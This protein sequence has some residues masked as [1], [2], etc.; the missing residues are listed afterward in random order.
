[1]KK[2]S[3]L[4]LGAF[5]TLSANAAIIPPGG[6]GG[7][8]WLAASNLAY[9]VAV[10][11]AGTG[12][13]SAV[14]AT[15]IAQS[16]IAA[17]NA[18]WQPI[19][20]DLTTIGGLGNQLA[21]RILFRDLTDHT[22]KYLGVGSGLEIAGTTLN[23]SAGD[24]IS[25]SL[26]NAGLVHVNM[27][28]ATRI[29]S[30]IDSAGNVNIASFGDSLGAKVSEQIKVL[31]SGTI[32]T[33]G[34]AFVGGIYATH[35]NGAVTNI[36]ANTNWFLAH[37]D[38]GPSGTIE[39]SNSVGSY[40]RANTNHVYYLQEPGA[41]TFKVQSSLAGGAWTDL[42]TIDA[43]G[44]YG[45]RV[46]TNT[47]AAGD[48]YRLRVEGVTGAVKI[49][50]GALWY[51]LSRGVR[52]SYLSE[53][54]NEW[55]A[56]TRAHTNVTH[57]ILRALN[58]TTVFAEA[59]DNADNHATNS[60]Q[61]AWLITNALRSDFVSIGT[62]PDS[63][64]TDVIRAQNDYDKL[65]SITN[66]FSFYDAR[67]L[68]G[69]YAQMTNRFGADDGVHR[70]ASADK[71]VAAGVANELDL[72]D[73]I[74]L[75]GSFASKFTENTFAENQTFSRQVSALA[76]AVSGPTVLLTGIA[77]NAGT[78]VNVVG[79]LASGQVVKAP[80]GAAT[81]TGT[82]THVTFFDGA[83]NPAG[84]AGMTYDKTTDSLSVSG[85]VGA[86]TLQSA[87][88][89]QGS[90]DTSTLGV[91]GANSLAVTT[92]ASIGGDAT[93]LARTI[94]DGP[95]VRMGQH[96]GTPT[97]DVSSTGT[98][99]YYFATNASYTL[100]FSGAA[101]AWQRLGI[102]RSNYSASSIIETSSLPVF[103]SRVGSNVTLKSISPGVTHSMLVTNPV[104][105]RWEI[106]REIAPEVELRFGTG[107]IPVT[108]GNVITISVGYVNQTNAGVGGANTNFTGQATDGVVYIDGGTTNV[109]FVAIMPGTT[110]NTYLP[111]YIITN[112][113]TTARQ[114]SFSSVTNFLIPL[115]F[116]DSVSLPIT[117]TNKHRLLFT[118]I[119][120]GSN[121][122]W[123][124]KQ[125]TNGF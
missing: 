45:G 38:L 67:A 21:D 30:A 54:G 13:I 63:S 74:G 35:T 88:I 27:H 1:M 31:L 106:E 96:L 4:L 62:T 19:D 3:A 24:V 52:V 100:N 34:Y 103:D 102:I 7:L 101:V 98:N 48:D 87:I 70:A 95:T 49:F 64:G 12:G 86:G 58:I 23:S 81:V 2:L 29:R 11:I 93:M 14:V 36:L 57:P 20:A 83:N 82:D 42:A 79:Q 47:V 71:Y 75:G 18:N 56:Y 111:T 77:S 73:S 112:L 26:T 5:L 37:H 68:V 125:A 85:L 110:G 60:T 115:Q 108:N 61:I 72:M 114:F 78:V 55:S 25:S 107:V 8:A 120:N 90:T 15:N 97:V 16:E 65:W 117:I 40:T 66:G 41:G 50:G 10:N 109:N 46:A 9:N 121:V 104:T 105:G 94:M 89:Q 43:N 99:T 51:S 17:S 113:T 69:T 22:W 122:T 92:T 6:G 39:W 91:V 44:T 84:D 124:A 33:N 116:Y 123:A 118:A 76:L 119:V 53:G 80:L 59:S 28:K 32:G